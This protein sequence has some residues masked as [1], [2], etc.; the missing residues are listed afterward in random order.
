[1]NM[2][3]LLLIAAILSAVLTG[4][5]RRYALASNLI[6]NPNQRSSHTIPTPRGGG[7]AIVLIFLV[8]LPFLEIPEANVDRLI[9]ALFGAGSLV[10]VAGFIDDHGHIPAH[11]RLCLH[12][13]AAAWALFWLGGL[14]PVAVFDRSIDLG[15]VGHVL[16]LLYLVWLL[17]LYNFMDGINGIAGIEALT[18]CIAG[19]AVF[20]L[21]SDGSLIWMV[22]MLLLAAS[23]SGFLIWNF[24]VA[25]IFMGDAGSGFIGIVLGI[26][27]IQAAS[28]NP[29]LLWV[30]LI[31][32]AAFIV[33][34][35]VT[36]VRR[37]QRGEKFYEAH[38]SHAYQY[39]ARKYASHSYVSIAFGLIN[40]LWLLPIAI[41]VVQ[42]WLDGL[43]G[44]IIA[45]LPLI[46]LA[47]KFKAGAS[48]QQEV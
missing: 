39:A 14:P 22:P 2:I 17:N 12:C 47:F 8:L 43:V 38:R 42:D 26:I 31:L 20:A 19:L 25:K 36:L 6:D 44:L 10:A 48:D 32:L 13:L 33:D 11:W 27:S 18:V 45:Y 21:S 24:P 30:W 29:E 1:M 40:L 46:F 15:W 37:I 35:T 34:A 41:V 9:W 7:L 16:G 28:T 5:L 4:L 23:V 3:F